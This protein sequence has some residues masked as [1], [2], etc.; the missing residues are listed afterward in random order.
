MYLDKE[1]E[2]ILKGEKG[3]AKAKALEVIVKV[4]EA[5]GA[6]G[7]VKIK[8]AHISGVSYSNIGDAGL[9]LIR[10]FYEEGAKFSVPATVNP[11]GLDLDDP[12]F[13]NVD[14][15]YIEKQSLILKYL[16]DMGADLIL[17]CIPYEIN[18]VKKYNLLPGDHVAWG[19]SNAVIYANSVLGL[20]TNREGGPLALMAAI[21]GYTYNFGLHEDKNRIPEVE[22]V[23]EEPK[24]GFNEALAGVLGEAIAGVHDLT[25]PP[26][27]RAPMRKKLCFK[28]FFAALGAA[29]DIGMVYIPGLTPERLP[30]GW[31][32]QERVAVEAFVLEARLDSLRPKSPDDVDLIYVGCPHMGADEIT[33]LYLLLKSLGR[34]RKKFVVSMPRSLIFDKRVKDIVDELSGLGVKVLKDTCLIVSPLN[35]KDIGVLTNS[36]KAYFY[37]KRRGARVYLAPLEDIVLLATVGRI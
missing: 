13:F 6:K 1:A 21:S 12:S 27:V 5:L 33:E 3:W 37:L 11:I 35:L 8:H 30:E 25:S 9:D 18:V 36:Y 16:K 10:K 31:R 32:P 28:E 23:V 17:S 19:E 2:R 22:Y 4:G 7:L 15:E 14:K 29:G 24:K 26:L 34:V 20:R